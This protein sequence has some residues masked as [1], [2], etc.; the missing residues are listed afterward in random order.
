M[1]A[2]VSIQCRCHI[3]CNDSSD[4]TSHWAPAQTLLM[5]RQW[6]RQLDYKIS[7]CNLVDQH[8]TKKNAY[9]IIIHAQCKLAHSLCPFAAHNSSRINTRSSA[10]ESERIL[11][12]S[13]EYLLVRWAATPI[14]NLHACYVTSTVS[15]MSVIAEGQRART[16]A[17][18]SVEVSF[19]IRRLV[20][21]NEAHD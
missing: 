21:G 9:T 13:R 17:F 15:M 2:G 6:T 14:L 11:A 19:P 16:S 12:C 8:K 3:Q 10:R 20:A 1:H 4:P 5:C 18:G 7:T